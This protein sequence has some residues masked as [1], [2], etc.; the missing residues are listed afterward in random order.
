MYSL[1][2]SLLLVAASAHADPATVWAIGDLHGDAACA[3]YWVSRTG[4]VAGL[5]G[6]PSGWAWT[7]PAAALV[8]MGDYVDKGPEARAVLQFVRAL[9]LRFGERVHALLGNHELNLLADRSRPS[10]LEPRSGGG[11]NFRYLELAW[12]AAHPAQY[13]SWLPPGERESPDG[14]AAVRSLLRALGGVYAARRHADV[15]VAAPEGPQQPGA[16]AS[17]LEW[18]AN[19]GERQIAA[20]Q[21]AAWQR[22]YLSGVS[23]ASPLGRWLEARPLTVVLADTLFVHGGVSAELAVRLGSRGA[24]EALNADFTRRSSEQDLPGLLAARPEAYGLV[25]FRGLHGDCA[26]VAAVARALNVS[27]VAVGH[28]PADAVRVR[29]GGSLLALDSALGRWFR[30]A[31]NHYCGD[32]GEEGGGEG[33]PRRAERCEGQV[34]RLARAEGGS[35]EA[36]R[37]S[38]AVVASDDEDGAQAR[39]WASAGA[40]AQLH[41]EAMLDDSSSRDECEL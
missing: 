18:I 1:M 36:G 13:A 19:S 28:T 16:S 21:L 11:A 33:C 6:P 8:F 7:D 35:G 24:L 37:W 9:T 17:I 4:L 41:E 38:V 29:C 23:S 22:A 32:G 14:Q 26:Q 39:R 40:A 5:D 30:A 10:G 27:R 3:R 31:G 2:H 25:E 20:R 12:G 34:V 15:L